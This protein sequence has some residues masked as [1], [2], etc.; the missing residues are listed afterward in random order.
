MLDVEF[1]EPVVTKLLV[2]ERRDCHH[3]FESFSSCHAS[4]LG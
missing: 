2:W 3:F 1:E 4:A